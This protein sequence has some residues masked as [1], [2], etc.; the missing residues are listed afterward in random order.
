MLRTPRIGA[1]EFLNQFGQ[2][3]AL[4]Q[5]QVGFVGAPQYAATVPRKEVASVAAGVT[6]VVAEDAGH[7]VVKVDRSSREE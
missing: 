6:A 7:G 5:S 3:R 1:P 2:R 4:A